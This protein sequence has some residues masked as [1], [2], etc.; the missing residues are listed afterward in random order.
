MLQW[1]GKSC[2]TWLLPTSPASPLSHCIP[3]GNFSLFPTTSGQS[4]TCSCLSR[5]FY[6]LSFLHLP[7]PT[8]FQSSDERSL[9]EGSLPGPPRLGGS[10]PVRAKCPGVLFY[11]TSYSYHSCNQVLNIWPPTK[12]ETH[13]DRY[14][15]IQCCSSST[16]HSAMCMA[17]VSYLFVDLILW[18]AIRSYQ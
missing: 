4:Y 16:N 6:V 2:V 7:S 3:H 9:P 18:N 10:P 11:S 5:T 12:Y 14:C 8:H 13:E 15:L 17:G 1:S